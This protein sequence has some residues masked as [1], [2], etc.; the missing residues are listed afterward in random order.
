MCT[1]MIY[2]TRDRYFG[3]TLD[4]ER[5]FG[6]SVVITPRNFPLPFRRMPAL[7]SH[8]AFLGMAAVEEG[9]PLYYDAVNENGL[10]M[11]GLL[12][13]GYAQYSPAEEGK[14][15]LAPFELIPWI[16]GQCADLR[17][18]QVLLERLHLAELSFSEQLPSA[19]LHWMIADRERAVVLESVAGA[20]KLYENPAGVL[21]NSPPFDYQLLRLAEY[22]RLSPDPQE[23]YSRGLGACGLPG[24]WSSSSRFVR[25]AFARQHGRCGEEEQESVGHFFRLLG[26]V[27]VPKGC[28]RTA[29]GDAY[30]RYTCCCNQDQ[31]IYYYTTY[32]SPAIR[33]VALSEA[34]PEG[35]DLVIYPLN[36]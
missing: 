9:Y 25:A 23:G 20:L 15:N 30:T 34:E 17:D 29:H 11:A 19:P 13:A 28:V 27:T 36:V 35:K 18:V 16:L 21:T 12:F 26:T 8:Y 3:R 2:K 22:Q 33:S 31:G 4:Y 7:E 1:A 6:E 24:D 5:S 14:E 32:E 10:A